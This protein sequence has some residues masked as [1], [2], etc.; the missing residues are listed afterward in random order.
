MEV[1][2]K[3]VLS[4]QDNIQL[5]AAQKVMSAEEFAEK[6]IAVASNYNTVYMSGVFGWPVT[7]YTID[8]KLRANPSWYTAERVDY[9]TKLIGEDYFGFDCVCFVKAILWGWDGNPENIY[10]GAKYE[11]N[12]VPDID[13]GQ[14]LNVCVDVSENFENIVVGQYLWTPGHCGI[15][16]GKGLAAEC[17]TRWK[18]GV[19]LTALAN[20][21]DQ[22]GNSG[23]PARK[24]TKCGFL[25]YVSYTTGEGGGSSDSDLSVLNLQYI[26]I[27]QALQRGDRGIEVQK[28]QLRI[29]RLSQ[30]LEDEVKAHSWKNGVPDG[31]FGPAMVQTLKN[32]QSQ[33]GLP[34]SGQCDAS[35]L[36]FLNDNEMERFLLK[37]IAEDK[38]SQIQQIVG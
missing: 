5:V 10:G 19:Q 14:M 38:L 21:P 4:G 1:N 27:N 23:Y 12:G 30:A 3:N 7:Q 22:W 24:W 29:A 11:S 32:V 26:Y 35:T 33:A 31:S 16:V 2:S 6:C 17:T 13:E 20:I 37:N 36:A 25:P 9:F 34:Q 15:Y 18:N 8:R 28:L